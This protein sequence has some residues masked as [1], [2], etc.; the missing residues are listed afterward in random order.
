MRTYSH[1][2]ETATPLSMPLFRKEMRGLQRL[3]LVVCG[4]IAQRAFGG[5]FGGSPNRDSTF[6]VAVLTPIPTNSPV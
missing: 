2:Q 5:E 4:R 3:R 6:V 1:G